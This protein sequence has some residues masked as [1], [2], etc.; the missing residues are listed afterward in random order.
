MS[1]TIRQRI[2][3][4]VH[5]RLKGVTIS[6]GY[7]TNAGQTVYSHLPE[8][9]DVPTLP[10]LNVADIADSPEPHEATQLN[11]TLSVRVDGYVADGITSAEECRALIGDIGEAMLGSSDRTWGGLAKTTVCTDA[12]SIEIRQ[13]SDGTVGAVRLMFEIEFVTARGDW[14]TAK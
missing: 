9:L 12:G 5:T 3:D 11:H 10:C 1:D 2:M 14:T 8:N 7:A 4:A 13:W 6:G